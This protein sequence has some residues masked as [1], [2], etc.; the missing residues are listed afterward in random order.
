MSSSCFKSAPSLMP[1]VR[2][3]RPLFVVETG[4]TTSAAPLFMHTSIFD[5]LLVVEMTLTPLSI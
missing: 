5:R 3:S 4:N 2:R 1:K